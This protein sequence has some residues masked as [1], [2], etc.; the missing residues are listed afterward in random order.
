VGL[1]YLRT[2]GVATITLS[3][4]SFLTQLKA[5][6]LNLLALAAGLVILLATRRAIRETTL[7]SAWCWTLAA[8]VAWAA[9]SLFQANGPLQFAAIALSFCPAVALLGAKRPQ[10]LA[11]NFVVVSLWA[12]VILPAAENLLLHPGRPVEMGDARGWFLWIL[13][14]LAPINFSPTRHWL[15]SILLAAGQ[16]VA[17]APHLP[18]LRR[19]LIAHAEVVGLV[20]AAVAIVAAWAGRFTSAPPR[21]VLGY[22]R[23]WL[24][25]RNT[26]GLFWSLRVQE[27][28]NAAARQYG[29]PFEVA[30]SGFRSKADGSRLT[31]IDPA[32]EPALRTSLKGLLRRFV[33]NRWI[34]ERTSHELD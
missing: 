27:R 1:I 9:A 29:W 28:I 13:I 11:W 12:I 10:H 17:L 31:A 26:F 3:A 2:K 6:V 4:A 24:D 19:D 25:F 8:L 23:L 22:D 21:S 33:S 30:W 5:P 14:L 32:I 34:A 15:A 7:T 18:L 16:I 20:L